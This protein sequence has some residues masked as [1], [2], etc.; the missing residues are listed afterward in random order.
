[1]NKDEFETLK[2][3]EYAYLDTIDILSI[4]KDNDIENLE[5]LRNILEEDYEDDYLE[6]N[7]NDDFLFNCINLSDFSH[8]MRKR[9]NIDFREEVTYYFQP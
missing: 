6:K 1:M 4:Q 8:Y 9:Y 3:Q 7:S 2:K 5:E